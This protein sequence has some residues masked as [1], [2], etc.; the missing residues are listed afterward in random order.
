MKNLFQSLGEVIAFK[1]T[2]NGVLMSTNEADV[3]VVV[4]SESIIRV[5]IDK[6]D[7]APAELPLCRCSQST[8]SRFYSKRDRGCHFHKYVQDQSV[9]ICEAIENFL[10]RFEWESS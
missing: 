7:S 6:T 1:E 8:G 10:H 5:Y 4:Y 3:R 2:D 9:D